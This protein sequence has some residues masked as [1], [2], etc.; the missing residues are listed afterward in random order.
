MVNNG[1]LRV[2]Y[3]HHCPVFGGASKSLIEAIKAF[4]KDSVEPVFVVPSGGNVKTIFEELGKPVYSSLGISQFDHTYSGHYRSWRWL[5]LLRE[6]FFLLPTLLV[7]IKVKKS[8]KKFD[9]IHINE[10]TQIPSLI[11]SKW[12]F[13][14]TPVLLHIRCLMKEGTPLRTR[15]LNFII[16]KYADFY[17]AIDESVNN[18]LS[19]KIP[20]QIIHNG[21]NNKDLSISEKQQGTIE[22]VKIAFISNLMVS[23]GILDFL[24]AA[25]LCKEKDLKVKLYIFGAPARKPNKLFGFFLSKAGFYVDMVA[26]VKSFIE[27]NKLEDCVEYRGFTKNIRSVLEE[28]DLVCFPSHLN[29]LGRPIFE[30]AFYGCPSIVTTRDQLPSDVFINNETGLCSMEKNPKELAKSMEYFCTRPDEILRMGK[31]AFELANANFDI[32]KNALKLYE[33]YKSLVMPL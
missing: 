30:A 15:I 5:I 2:L 17:I 13:P 3:V 23:K 31:N 4:P 21:F 14:S 7:L 1:P 32:S 27:E 25:K 11:F 16:N 29:A 12:L 22:F 33:R 26:L 6:L 9:L 28:V 8:E 20:G 19:L 10:I 24:E 18:T